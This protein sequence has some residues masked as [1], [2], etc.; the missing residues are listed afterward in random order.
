MLIFKSR[1]KSVFILIVFGFFLLRRGFPKCSVH[2]L[3]L[4][5]FCQTWKPFVFWM[6]E[7]QRS[8][9]LCPWRRLWDLMEPLPVWKA[10]GRG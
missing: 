1:L 3:L 5:T 6:L 2:L 10:W 4:W 8:S 9:C 7:R